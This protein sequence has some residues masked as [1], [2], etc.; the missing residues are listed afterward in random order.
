VTGVKDSRTVKLPIHPDHEEMGAREITVD[1]KDGT[2][3]LLVSKGDL[4]ILKL[5][6]IVRLMELFNVKVTK[7]SAEAVSSEL[8]SEAYAE[9][10]KANAPLIHW[11]PEQRNC[12]A[13]VVMPTAERIDGLAEPSLT[14]CHV[15]EVIQLVRFGFGRVDA[16]GQESV[17]VYFGHQ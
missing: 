2:A 17:V 7:T 9:A 16:V 14:T 8:H 12:N 3:R 15:N 4:N 1:A 13:A 5:G 11:L 10:K 6:A